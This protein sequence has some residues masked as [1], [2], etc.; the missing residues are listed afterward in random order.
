MPQRH[1]C[2]TYGRLR[3]AGTNSTAT[4]Q[5]TPEPAPQ[6]EARSGEKPARDIPKSLSSGERLSGRRPRQHIHILKH[7]FIFSPKCRGIP[8]KQQPGRASPINAASRNTT[9]SRHVG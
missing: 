4:E 5:G 2:H 7:E 3:S 6:Q 8:K 9:R 1:S